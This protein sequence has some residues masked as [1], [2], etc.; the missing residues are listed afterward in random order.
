M[1]GKEADR[2]AHSTVNI[3]TRALLTAVTA[4]KTHEADAAAAVPTAESAA[5]V[6]K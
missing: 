4:H 1:H 3:Y 5:A 6:R 2:D